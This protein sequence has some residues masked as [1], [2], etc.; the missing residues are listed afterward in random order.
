MSGYQNS[1]QF[2]IL[3]PSFLFIC[4]LLGIILP[5]LPNCEIF[6]YKSNRH[7]Q[8]N[9]IQNQNVVNNNTMQIDNNL[10]IGKNTNTYVVPIINNEYNGYPH[11]QSN[12]NNSLDN[13]NKNH[14]EISEDQKIDSSENMGIAPLPTDIQP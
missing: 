6:K 12:D 10:N 9:N 3:L 11:I 7:H 5:N 4:N 2:D 8:I 1:I 14:S 13:K